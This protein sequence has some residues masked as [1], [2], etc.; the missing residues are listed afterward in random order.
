MSLWNCLLALT[1]I[2][3]VTKCVNPFFRS[4]FKLSW[5]ACPRAL[6]TTSRSSRCRSG[7]VKSTCVTKYSYNK[8]NRRVPPSAEDGSSDGLYRGSLRV[9]RK[10]QSFLRLI[11]RIQSVTRVASSRARQVGEHILPFGCVI[12][13]RPLTPLPRPLQQFLESCTLLIFSGPPPYQLV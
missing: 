5:S 8:Y 3:Y 10:A 7:E 11:L 1:I 9:A 2:P 13:P 4:P 6:A 12:P